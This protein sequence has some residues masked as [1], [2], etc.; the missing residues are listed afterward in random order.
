M[1]A[2]ADRLSALLTMWRTRAERAVERERRG[3]PYTT[4]GSLV[5]LRCIEDLEA[6][7]AGR[8]PADRFTLEDVLDAKRLLMERRET[9]RQLGDHLRLA[10]PAC[11]T[12]RARDPVPG[13][14]ALVVARAR[15]LGLP[16]DR[17]PHHVLREV[18]A[19]HYGCAAEP[20]ADPTTTYD[21][22][23]YEEDPP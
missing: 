8:A 12:L 9:P 6:V 4:R 11:H 10:T 3:E 15:E 20:P 5:L 14:A 19:A 16:L 18:A 13:F 23:P 22:S 17:V 1:T 21:F 7:A 2:E